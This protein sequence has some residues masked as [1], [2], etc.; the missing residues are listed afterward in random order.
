MSKCGRLGNTRPRMC[1]T[2]LGFGF[3][4]ATVSVVSKSDVFERANANSS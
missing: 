3:G 1:V 4:F 2:V